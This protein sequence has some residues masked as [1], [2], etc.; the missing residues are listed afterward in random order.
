VYLAEDLSLHRRVIV[1]VLLPSLAAH[2]GVRRA[3]RD[4]IVRAATLSHPHLARVFDG[5]QE[6]GAIFMI[7]EYLDGGSLEDI[8]SSGRVLS[9]DDVARLGRDVAGALSYVH[10]NGFVHADLSPDKLLFDDEGRV[11]VSDIALA[12]LGDAY[13]ERLS[14][15][16]V[17]YLSPE[18]ALGEPA[19]PESD[20]YSLALILFEA[21]TGVSAFDGL[22]V[23]AVLRARVNSPLPVRV[24]LGTLDMLLAQAAVSDPRLRLNAE[25]FSNR[26]GAAVN[27]SAPLTLHNLHGEVPILSQFTPT[28]P[29]TSIGFRPPSPDQ[30]AGTAAHPLTPP[31]RVR[32]PRLDDADAGAPPTQSPPRRSA[33]Y[34]YE[35]LPPGRRRR[36]RR[37]GY[38]IAAAL[39]VILAVGAGAVWKLGLLNQDHVVPNLTSLTVSEASQLLKGDGFTLTVNQ[40]AVSQS[41]PVNEILAQAPSA[42]TK[43]KSG[44]DITVTISSGPTLVK[45]PTGLLGTSCASASAKLALSKIKAQ[46]PSSKSESSATVPVGDVVAVLY[47]ATR[48]PA[49]VPKG[50]TVVLAL[51]T[52]PSTATTTTTLPTSGTTTSTT[53]TTL[54]GEG[55]RAMPNVVGFDQAQVNAAMHKAQLY[56]QT[57]GPGADSTA[58]TSVVSE[59]PAAGT[60]VKWHATVILN[61][62]K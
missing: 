29:R 47:H 31:V 9:V 55:L 41:V 25:Q 60:M 11:R 58:W 14:L 34:G 22:S 42:G 28:E 59:D 39:L 33:P 3:F 50:A 19:G 38:L 2:E 23:D 17:R 36:P 44:L 30:V 6:S 8:L 13:R 10:A 45:L 40:H 53:T 27:D 52:G 26:L 48:N 7:T 32:A 18:Q 51:S 4:R 15:E 12:G 49:S 57:R 56:Y 5:G 37:W 1:K 24:E 35:P 62:Q 46:C 21:A 61:V 54:A 20:V 43:A 16:D